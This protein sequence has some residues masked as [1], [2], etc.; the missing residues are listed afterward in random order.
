[1]ALSMPNHKQIRSDNFFETDPP[2]NIM[3]TIDRGV[4]H[5]MIPQSLI[6]LMNAP[7]NQLVSEVPEDV[8]ALFDVAKGAFVYGLVYRPLLTMGLHYAVLAVE[9]ALYDRYIANDGKNPTATMGETIPYLAGEKR[10]L[11]PQIHA[12]QD[13]AT[14]Y[15]WALAMRNNVFAHPKFATT[16]TVGVSKFHVCA[17]LIN[18]LYMPAMS[19]GPR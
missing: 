17:D 10:R 18:A 13:F 7:K 6:N 11:L 12:S 4:A 15:H 16:F 19:G 9:A 5:P 14:G 2:G 8:S 1:M 3:M